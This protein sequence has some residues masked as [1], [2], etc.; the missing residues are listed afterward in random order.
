MNSFRT[1]NRV[2][3]W[4]DDVLDAGSGDVG[5]STGYNVCI[6][7]DCVMMMRMGMK[8]RGEGVLELVACRQ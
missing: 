6:N 5:R 4:E 2:L 1:A 7:D 3:F 8:V